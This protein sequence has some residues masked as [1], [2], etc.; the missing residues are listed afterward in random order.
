[1]VL[2]NPCMKQIY[3]ASIPKKIKVYDVFCKEQIV[4]ELA[5]YVVVL[6]ILCSI[7]YNFKNSLLSFF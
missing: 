4:E 7:D 1:M 6:P 5:R 3:F 2:Y